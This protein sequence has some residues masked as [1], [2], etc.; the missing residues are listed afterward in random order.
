MTNQVFIPRVND[1]VRAKAFE[2]VFKVTGVQVAG[3]KCFIQRFNVSKLALMD[4]DQ[5]LVACSTLTPFR[6][7]ASQA[8]AR[9]VREATEDH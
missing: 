4:E 1:L 9:I 7:D 3:D 5:I 8:A 2:G 6:E